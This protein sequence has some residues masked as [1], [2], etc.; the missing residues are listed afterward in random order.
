[1]KNIWYIKVIILEDWHCDI[2]DVTIDKRGR[3]GHLRSNKH[4]QKVNKLEQDKKKSKEPEKI[5]A[6]P[7]Q[8]STT[9]VDDNTA[10]N[11]EKVVTL[12]KK[13]KKK[14]KERIGEIRIV[15]GYEKPGEKKQDTSDK[16]MGF[17]TN[18]K[19]QAL[20]STI[21]SLLQTLIA[22]KNPTPP[23]QKPKYGF[24]RDTGEPIDF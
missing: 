24:D 19:N 17:L 14:K 20:L 4:L 11:N 9:M 12:D 2:C 7:V 21:G 22:Q 15:D 18:P 5:P 16:V 6:E 1:M 23:V 3:P 10:K 8:R 13:G